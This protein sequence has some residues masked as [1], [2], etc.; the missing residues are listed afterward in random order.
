MVVQC[1]VRASGVERGESGVLV[2]SIDRLVVVLWRAA[3]GIS[4]TAA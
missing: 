1:I 2:I 4:S 3:D